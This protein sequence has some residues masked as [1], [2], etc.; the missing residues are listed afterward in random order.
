MLPRAVC[1]EESQSQNEIITGLE[2]DL[3]TTLHY[4]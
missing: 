1:V 3:C 2:L 4:W